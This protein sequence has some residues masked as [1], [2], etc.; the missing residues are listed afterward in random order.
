MHGQ[1]FDAAS[2]K[3]AVPL[4][5]LG[6]RVERNG[7]PGTGDPERYSCHNCSLYM[8]VFDAY[9]IRVPAKL[10]SPDWLQNVRFDFDTKL[11]AGATAAQFHA[12][13]QNLLA[14]RFK[15]AVH[16][17]KREMPVYELAV[18]KNGPKFKE[19]V[20]K[21]GALAGAPAGQVKTDGDG[22]PILAAGTSMAAVG[23]HARMR[24]ENQT[25]DWFAGMLANQLGSLVVDATGLKGK[26]DF[27]LSW[28]VEE[29]NGSPDMSGP[30]L[31][32][33]LQSE[34]GLKVERKKGMV[35]VL[36]VDHAEKTPG[37]N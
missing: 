8:M 31:V 35:E 10:A 11:P 19:S 1:T 32:T 9:E 4:E 24:S 34:L 6:M 26:Y 14:E 25:M 30:D 28:V 22:Y 33:A 3:T 2:V 23:G 37:G 17:E 13:L 20:P 5:P 27:V 21:E 16:R 15:L 7:G 36:V 12:M 18:A 29:R